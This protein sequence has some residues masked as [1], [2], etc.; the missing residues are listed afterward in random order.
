[1]ITKIRTPYTRYL[2]LRELPSIKN[3]YNSSYQCTDMFACSDIWRS[4]DT[5]ILRN[6][7]NFFLTI[8][9]RGLVELF[10]SHRRHLHQ[11]LT[12]ITIIGSTVFTKKRVWFKSMYTN[13]HISSIFQK[14][15]PL[16]PAV[17]SRYT[18]PSFIPFKNIFWPE[19]YLFVS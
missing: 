5:D 9:N 18:I 7:G 8:A 12:K 4:N 14:N 13:F 10:G 1:M 2:T 19:F 11:L 16:N 6:Y 15:C 17:F 3:A